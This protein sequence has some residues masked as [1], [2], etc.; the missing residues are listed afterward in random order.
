MFVSPILYQTSIINLHDGF[1]ALFL[2]VQCH[3]NNTMLC[4]C[5]CWLDSLD[6]GWLDQQDEHKNQVQPART[7]LYWYVFFGTQMEEQTPHQLLYI[8]HSWNITF[9]ILYLV[10]CNYHR[11]TSGLF[12]FYRFP[13]LGFLSLLRTVS[14]DSNNYEA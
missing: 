11:L 8:L 14:G 3:G 4:G 7:L 5:I 9:G 2:Q 10:G 13:P 1:C 6:A 12:L